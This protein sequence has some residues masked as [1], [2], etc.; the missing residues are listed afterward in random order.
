MANGK[1]MAHVE[2]RLF[3]GAIKWSFLMSWGV[4]AGNAATMMVL[5]A[6]LGPHAYG[7]VSLASIVIILFQLLVEL[8]ISQ[9]LI[10]FR[11]IEA[12][13]FDSAF[14]LISCTAWLIFFTLLF[15]RFVIYGKEF[16]ELFEIV[17]WLSIRV[18]IYAST[19]VHIAVL[20]REM[21]IKPIAIQSNIGVIAGATTGITMALNGFGYWS[22]VAQQV[23]EA[24]VGLLVIWY[25]SNWR[26]RLKITFQSLK[27]IF[28]YSSAT[29]LTNLG[30]FTFM[31]GDAAV[32]GYFFGPTAVGIYRLALRLVNLCSDISTQA[33][34]FAALPEMARHQNDP[35]NLRVSL[36]KCLHIAAVVSI[37]LLGVL[38]ATFD[39]LL[40]FL[41]PKWQDARTPLLLLCIVGAIQVVS[42]I[43]TS[44]LQA[45]GRPGLNAKLTWLWGIL[46]IAA[47]ATIGKYFADAQPYEQ[48]IA[49]CVAHISLTAILHLPTYVFI[50]NRMSNI[51]L[52]DILGVFFP[53]TLSAV[54][55]FVVI[56]MLR[57]QITTYVDL[58]L[59]Q[60]A[61]TGFLAVA[62]LAAMLFLVDVRM[63]RY[64]I[65][66]VSDL[67]NRQS[68]KLS[69]DG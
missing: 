4:A 13:H 23:V 34:N 57:P 41:G 30:V 19:I 45:I 1:D 17:F 62:V 3:R 43:S 55:V 44:M 40:L 2:P 64:T 11:K 28:K 51:T 39:E 26:P 59:L 60:L 69:K 27:D 6:I 12:S 9:A 8:G 32:M 22:L 36:V 33:V 20:R 42:I 58:P 67:G 61:T 29:F 48:I 5:A 18:P 7:L 46:V 21:N 14:C 25:L 49:V 47:T 37:G 68:H 50:L 24:S 66:I 65:S 15:V 35:V 53:S 52:L 63:R 54:T 38:A 31:R 16:S 10:Q 56:D